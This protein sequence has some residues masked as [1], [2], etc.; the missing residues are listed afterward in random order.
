MELIGDLD[1]SSFGRVEDMKA[2]LEWTKKESHVHA[3][4]VPT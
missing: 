3:Y 1:K 2:S 4:C